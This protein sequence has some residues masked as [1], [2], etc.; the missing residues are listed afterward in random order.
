M[1]MPWIRL[2]LELLRREDLTT[3][4]AVVWAIICDLQ[5][6]T[7]TQQDLAEIAGCSRKA[8]NESLQR[9]A[10]AQL[11]TCGDQHGRGAAYTAAEILPP[12]RR[13]HKPERKEDHSYNLN[14]I[15]QL[16]KRI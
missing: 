4:D 7:V 6:R 14:E 16:M 2:P 10:A 11:I 8:V 1:Q 3:L 15:E 12:I 13:Q 9:L 5:G